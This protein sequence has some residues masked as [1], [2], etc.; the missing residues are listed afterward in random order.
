MSGYARRA[1]GLMM[2][3]G[4]LGCVGGVATAPRAGASVNLAT[5]RLRGGTGQVT[6]PLTC[7]RW[8]G[9]QCLRAEPR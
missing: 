7:G 9:S 4:A 6:C 3:M 1:A 2:I 8:R 5:L